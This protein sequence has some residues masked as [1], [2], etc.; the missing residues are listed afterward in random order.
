MPDLTINTLAGVAPPADPYA[1]NSGDV[2]DKDTFLKLLTTQLSNQDP[3]SPMKNEDF[4]AQLAQFSSLEQLMGMQT[5]MQ[6]VFDGIQAMNNSSMANLLGTDVVARSETVVWDGEGTRTLGWQ[7]EAAM[8]GATLTIL[9]S[10]GRPVRTVSVD[11][12]DGDGRYTWDGK[13]QSGRD[14]PPGSYTFRVTGTNAA[15]ETVV[16][17][18]LLEGRVDGMDYTTGVPLPSI[19]G[20]P[21]ALGDVLTLK[22]ANPE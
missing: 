2:A 18:T 9:D 21:V 12:T 20:T 8:S 1:R 5:T 14:L 10:A 13:D 17:E 19:D 22:L 3:T 7:S 4:L 6:A 15:G 16:A 11:G